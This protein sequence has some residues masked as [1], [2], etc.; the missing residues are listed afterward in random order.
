MYPQ[1]APNQTMNGQGTTQN[2]P[3]IEQG[4]SGPQPVKEI[5]FNRDVQ[6]ILWS[7]VQSMSEQELDVLDAVITPQTFPILVKL[8]P[9]MQLLFEQGSQVSASQPMMAQ[10]TGMP[11]QPQQQQPNPLSNPQSK[12]RLMG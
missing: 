12:N 6:N 9:E 8:F 11:T 5:G 4:G 3:Q 1:N 10:G 2:M 7:R